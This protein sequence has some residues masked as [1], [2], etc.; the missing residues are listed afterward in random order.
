MLF[1][2]REV[3]TKLD[4]YVIITYTTSLN[5]RRITYMIQY[6][7]FWK[8]LFTYPLLLLIYSNILF[9]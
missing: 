9:F 1:Q 4:V 8:T 5:L 3:Y 6:L 2:K 7:L